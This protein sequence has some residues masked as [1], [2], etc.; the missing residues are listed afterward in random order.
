M[1][2]VR[3]SID[4]IS[5]ETNLIHLILGPDP[6]SLVIGQSVPILLEE[7]VDT[8]NPSVPAIVKI[9]EGQ[10]SVLCIG[11]LSLQSILSPHSLRINEFCFP[12]LKYISMLRCEMRQ[13]NG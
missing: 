2:I 11:L 10:S 6:P 12:R 9:L 3:R 8:R 4:K 7:S 13:W 1:H 5:K